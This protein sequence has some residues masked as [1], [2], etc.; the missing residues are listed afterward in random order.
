MNIVIIVSVC[1]RVIKLRKNGSQFEF[2]FRG[3]YAGISLKRV[4]L[5]GAVELA[6]QKNKEYLIKVKI[7]SV[8]EGVLVGE[9]LRIRPLDEY[10]DKS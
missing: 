8:N 9:I 7:T 10:W 3:V 4:I 5:T 2:H 6:V 1:S